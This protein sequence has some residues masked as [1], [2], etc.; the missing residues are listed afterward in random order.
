MNLDQQKYKA[1]I[2]KFVGF[3]FSTPLGHLI[4]QPYVFKEFNSFAWFI[5]Y[6]TLSV[7]LAIIGV[8]FLILGYNI[9]NPTRRS[10]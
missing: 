2:C 1:D 7:L 6:C 8:G 9:Y 5:G 4:L 3:A 10:K